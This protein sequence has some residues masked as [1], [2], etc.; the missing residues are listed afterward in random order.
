[1]PCWQPSMPQATSIRTTRPWWWS[2]SG[3]D[4]AQRALAAGEGARNPPQDAICAERRG[5]RGLDGEPGVACPMGT[6]GVLPLASLLVSPPET[7]GPMAPGPCARADPA[8]RTLEAT[9]RTTATLGQH[10]PGFACV[11]FR[12]GPK[13]ARETIARARGM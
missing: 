1:M 5:P 7:H 11:R 13:A 6:R 10:L 4:V 2:P 12:P 9:R 8:A 3:H